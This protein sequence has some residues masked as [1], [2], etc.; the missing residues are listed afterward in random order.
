MPDFIYCLNSSTIKPVPILDKI[1]IAAEVG[2][3]AIELWH[4]DIDLHVAGGGSVDDVRKAVDDHGLQVP[5]TIFLKGWFDTV[6]EPHRQALDECRRRMEQ[7]AIVGATFCVGGP[8][9]NT[10]LDYELGASNY[11]ELLD[12]GI[13][14]F[15]VRPAMEYLGFA[16]QLNTIEDALEIISRSGHPQATIVLD[17]FHCFRGGGPIESIGRLG[18]AQV[19]ISHFN[20]SPADPP[21]EQ[22]HDANRVMPGE[23]IVDLKLY[24][25]QLRA[26]RYEGCL[27]LELFNR[28][29]WD[30]DPLEVARIGLQKMR[31]AA[32]G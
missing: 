11:S 10:G 25:D 28:E 21:R 18:A 20:D 16:E 5:T 4:D 13:N 2:Y 6:G 14:E 9:L 12:V 17:P 19:A 24:C 32:A 27:S 8:P 30:Q 22:Q 23:G 31:A 1:R 26:I 15:G 7:A 3:E 29:L